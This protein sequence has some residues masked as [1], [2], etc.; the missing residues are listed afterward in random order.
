MDESQNIEVYKIASNIISDGFKSAGIK[1]GDEFKALSK[2]LTAK[3][4][5][6]DKYGEEHWED[7]NTAI[8]RGVEL[9]LRLRRLLDNKVDDSKSATVTHKFASEDLKVL[10]KIAADLTK[11]KAMQLSDSIQNG[12]ILDV[13]VRVAEK[14]LS[15]P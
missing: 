12:E 1:E 4:M 10:E 3:K 8:G 2:L 9:T 14:T 7:D 13:E 6:V 5:T 11:L 15:R